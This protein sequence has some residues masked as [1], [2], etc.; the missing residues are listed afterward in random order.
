MS[1]PNW[2]DV[3]YLLHFENLGRAQVFPAANR[4]GHGMPSHDLRDVTDGIDAEKAF[5]EFVEANRL[6]WR[7]APVWYRIPDWD[8]PWYRIEIWQHK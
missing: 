5:K 3:P 4:V 6:D 7:L 8:Q 1:E 2:D